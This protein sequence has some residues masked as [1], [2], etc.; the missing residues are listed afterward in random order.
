MNEIRSMKKRL[1]S[2]TRNHGTRRG[3]LWLLAK[4]SNHFILVKTLKKKPVTDVSR[5]V[6][7][8]MKKSQIFSRFPESIEYSLENEKHP[9]FYHSK[10]HGKKHNSFQ[11]DQC[12]L[13]VSLEYPWL[14][15]SLDGIRTCSPDELVIE[16]KCHFKGKDLHLKFTFLL[17]SVG[18]LKKDG[19]D[20]L[21]E[22]H[23]FKI[24]TGMDAA[25]LK[26]RDFVTFTR[27]GIHVVEVPFNSIFWESVMKKAES[28]YM[29]QTIPN[30]FNKFLTESRCSSM[31]LS[32]TVCGL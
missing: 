17:N 11:L 5:T 6:S 3:T 18:G 22:V 14:G 8:F 20:Y 16:F 9:K 29:N 15:A 32:V 13:L 10:I 12:G 1:A 2:T 4:K 25:G 30:I 31:G 23:H 19:H 24:Q 26:K 21:N 7:N 27:E 28:F